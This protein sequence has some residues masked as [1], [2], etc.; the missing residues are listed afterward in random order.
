M[1]TNGFLEI[2]PAPACPVRSKPE[3]GMLPGQQGAVAL[4]NIWH[5]GCH[6]DHFHLLL[7]LGASLMTSPH[8]RTEDLLPEEAPRF[9][10]PIQGLCN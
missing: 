8:N 10:S 9:H 3:G 7:S 2:H 6:G 4:F 5:A 1:K